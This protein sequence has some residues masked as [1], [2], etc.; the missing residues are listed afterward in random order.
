MGNTMLL[1]GL[2][3]G[4]RAVV[5]AVDPAAPLGRRLMDLGFV[6]GTEVRCIGRSPFGD[7]SAYRLGGTVLALRAADG[8]AVTVREAVSWD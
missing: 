2:R 1:K 5:E 8:A 4:Q 6:E 7:P 3:P